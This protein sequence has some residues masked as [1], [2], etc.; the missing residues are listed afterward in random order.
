MFHFFTF[1]RKWY[2]HRSHLVMQGGETTFVYSVLFFYSNM[3]CISFA[4]IAAIA[5]IPRVCCIPKYKNPPVGSICRFTQTGEYYV[6]TMNIAA[7]NK[8][9]KKWDSTELMDFA[10]VAFGVNHTTVTKVSVFIHLMQLVVWYE[11]KII[12]FI[13]ICGTVPYPFM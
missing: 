6:G 12:L 8:T 9:C 4:M 7:S 3:F 1:K 13:Y 5:V 2:L 10:E 11:I